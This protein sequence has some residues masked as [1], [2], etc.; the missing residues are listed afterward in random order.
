MAVHKANLEVSTV[1]HTPTDTLSLVPYMWHIF[2]EI[3]LIGLGLLLG[4]GLPP[5]G[6]PILSRAESDGASEA[7]TQ[8]TPLLTLGIGYVSSAAPN[9]SD[10][11]LTSISHIPPVTCCQSGGM[12]HGIITVFRVFIGM[13]KRLKRYDSTSNALFSLPGSVDAKFP[14]S[15]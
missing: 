7:K 13:T 6:N 8:R 11:S 2:W 10:P 3:Y 5:P 14:L 1:C 9:S 12:D 4:G 15:A